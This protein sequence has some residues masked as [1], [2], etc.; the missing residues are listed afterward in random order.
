METKTH[1][2]EEWILDLDAI[3]IKLQRLI[4]V[5]PLCRWWLSA[6]SSA[7]PSPWWSS[8]SSSCL[9]LSTGKSPLSPPCHC[10]SPC[11][12]RTTGGATEHVHWLHLIITGKGG[13]NLLTSLNLPPCQ[14]KGEGST[15]GER[16]RSAVTLQGLFSSAVSRE[17]NNGF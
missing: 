12:G 7:S 2:K 1:I 5:F 13:E 16:T 15:R 9:V 6:W 8:T 14:K 10:R 3:K 17:N 11:P 4:L